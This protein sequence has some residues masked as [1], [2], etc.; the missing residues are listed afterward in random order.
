MDFKDQATKITTDDSLMETAEHGNEAYPFRYYYEN[1]A[2]FDFNC[3]DWHWHSELEFVFVESGRVSFDVGEAHFELEAG[4]GVM[5]NSR[6]L[7][8]MQS[9]GDAV[10]PNFVFHPAFI[11]PQD[12]L[13]YEKYVNPV[14]TSPLEYV[15]FSPDRGW[16]SEALEAMK[17]VIA[18]HNTEPVNELLVS[19]SVQRLWLLVFDNLK[20][21][22]S[23][24]KAPDVHTVRLK[25]MMQYI[26]EN[27]AED[28]SLA[29][30]AGA[31]GISKT[32]AMQLFRDSLRITPV[33]YLISYR[34][35]RAAHLLANTEKKLAV[36][37]SETGF[38]GVDYFCR[39]FKKTYKM[40]PGEYRK[41]PAPSPR[42]NRLV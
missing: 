19:A 32:S 2:L 24:N 16:Q 37:A 29:D 11:A 3:V 25:L 1:L 13:I 9:A 8:R 33:N 23:G 10:I 17:A 35:K 41:L 15:I 38:A 7:H 39:S 31:A 20:A 26:H 30:I 14:I 27:Y 22:F 36:I 5:I 21:D 28:I 42:G 12:S 40:T 18:A 4:S 6:I 34:L